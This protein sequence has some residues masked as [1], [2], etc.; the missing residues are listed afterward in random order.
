MQGSNSFHWLKPSSLGEN[1]LQ[2]DL[3][4]FN[5]HN[6]YSS[7]NTHLEDHVIHSILLWLRYPIANRQTNDRHLSLM[8][9]LG[10]AY[11][12]SSQPSI[13][14]QVSRATTSKPIQPF[15]CLCP[16]QCE[17]ADMSSQLVQPWKWDRTNKDLFIDLQYWDPNAAIQICGLLR[18]SLAIPWN[19][20][21]R[22]AQNHG[23]D[24]QI[25]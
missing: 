24:V 2:P 10:G 15:Q 19:I 22:H 21:I 9:H 14:M 11:S 7:K 6:A 3:S 13:S 5:N 23:M 8:L 25:L 18:Y 12:D 17:A 16:A 20:A 1:F 4:G